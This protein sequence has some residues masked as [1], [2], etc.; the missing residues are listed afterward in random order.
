MWAR[1]GQRCYRFGQI[2]VKVQKKLPFFGVTTDIFPGSCE[3]LIFNCTCKREKKYDD[4]KKNP[5]LSYFVAAMQKGEKG[6]E[7]DL[8]LPICKS[9]IQVSI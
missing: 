7:I 5:F 8:I 2:R 9:F 4:E 3:N 1:N 6:S